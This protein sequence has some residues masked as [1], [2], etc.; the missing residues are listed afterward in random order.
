MKDP[1][2]LDGKVAAVIGAASGIGEAVAQGCARQG[3]IVACYDM[4]GP[5]AAKVAGRSADRCCC[6]APVKFT[7]L[8][9][10]ARSIPVAPSGS[11]QRWYG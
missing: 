5:R 9:E 3:A 11:M 6:G 4:D 8:Y 1:F 2:R 10:D 7:P